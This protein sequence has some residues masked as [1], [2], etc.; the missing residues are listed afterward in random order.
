MKKLSLAN[1]KY[2]FYPFAFTSFFQISGCQ[3]AL[4]LPPMEIKNAPEIYTALEMNV[5]QERPNAIEQARD[6][7][8]RYE[9]VIE[10]ARST[11][12][13]ESLNKIAEERGSLDWQSTRVD[14]FC[15]IASEADCINAISN[16]SIAKKDLKKK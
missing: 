13:A 14:A 6:I 15:K 2:I 4:Q 7:T 12:T 9:F 1:I 10:H 5:I 16:L 3:T 8:K 11:F